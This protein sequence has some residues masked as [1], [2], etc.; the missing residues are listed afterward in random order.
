MNDEQTRF[1]AAIGT[2][3]Q[4]L[5]VQQAAWLLNLNATDIPILVR[6]R[7]LLP[8]GN[9]PPNGQKF[10]ARSRMLELAADEK[11]LA[12]VSNAIHQHWFLKNHRRGTTGTT[13]E[14]HEA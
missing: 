5:T 1:F 2:G 12:K 8:L 7:L 10:F 11:W 13:A 6:A 4:R 9:P 14:S 3:P